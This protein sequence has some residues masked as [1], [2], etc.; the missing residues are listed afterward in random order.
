MGAG[1]RRRQVARPYCRDM[2]TDQAGSP[3][4]DG[5]PAD[6][7][8][9]SRWNTVQAWVG[10]T[11]DR[12]IAARRRS[13][14][15][16][17]AFTA[18]EH[19]AAVGGGVLAGAMAFRLFLLL[20]PLIFFLVALFG[21]GATLVNQ[22][23]ADLARHTGAGG[24]IAAEAAREAGQSQADRIAT[25]VIAGVT[26]LIGAFS[27]LKVLRVVHGL[28]WAE[29]VAKLL[30]PWRAVGVF[31]A[32]TIVALVLSALIGDLGRSSV[33]AG[34]A[35]ELL[36]LGCAFGIWLLISWHMP[37]PADTSWTTLVPGALLLALGAEIIHAVTI[38]GIALILSRKTGT[39]GAIGI[40][41]TLLFWAYL[42][43]RLVVASVV[44][45][46]GIRLRRLRPPDQGQ[47]AEPHD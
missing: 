37:R 3:S 10:E 7:P 39:Y 35:M 5:A 4:P 13:Q 16:D 18:V 46:A 8:R 42:V 25:I 30:H 20:V 36:Y 45:N 44:L 43:G 11:R 26:T 12:L 24:L 1:G 32:V 41:L 14:T 33:P 38:Y 40:A 22:S 17:A 47:P 29:P 27:A 15:V 34:V 23:P 6:A 9:T 21:F 2:A 19:D 28:V 31:I